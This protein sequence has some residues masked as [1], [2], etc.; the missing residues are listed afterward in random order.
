MS[1]S[2][3]VEKIWRFDLKKRSKVWQHFQINVLNTKEC[4]CIHCYHEYSNLGPTTSLQYHLKNIHNID[5]KQET[6]SNESPAASTSSNSSSNPPIVSYLLKMD[7]NTPKLVLARMAAVDRIPLKQLATSKDFKEG[8]AARG[9]KIPPHYPEQAKMLHD[10]STELK[11]QLKIEL[12][13][14]RLNGERFSIS[15]DEWTSL[16]NQRYMGLELYLKD[17]K[18]CS[19]GLRYV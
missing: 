8:W 12:A 18:R 14:R 17:H 19:L 2:K 15:C 6:K 9:I 5:V 16:R 13:E 1:D 3:K 4:K 11:E 10:F 7:T